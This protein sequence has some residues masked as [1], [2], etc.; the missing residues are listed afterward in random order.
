MYTY[1]KLQQLHLYS[2]ISTD[3]SE[4]ID[5][6]THEAGHAFQLYMSRDIAMHEINFPTLDSCEIHSMSMEFIT[7][8]WMELVL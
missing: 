3:T 2:L 7:Y 6:L 8:P 1:T 4:D 5:V